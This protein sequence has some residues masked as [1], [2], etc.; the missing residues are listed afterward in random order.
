MTRPYSLDLRR[1]VVRAV[2]AGMSCRA[3]A[4]RF[5]VSVSFVVKLM[6]RWRRQGTL[7][8]DQVGGWKRSKL[9]PHAEPVRALVA[10]EPDL[11]LAELHARLADQGIATSPAGVS[12]FLAACE[13]T[14]KKR[15]PTPPSRSARTSPRR[16]SRGGSGSR[17]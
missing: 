4:A 15:P 17:P 7:E 12:R 9:A 14:R 8:P 2:Q 11:T 5:E 1:R 3:S 6:Q 10:A 16:A 13:L